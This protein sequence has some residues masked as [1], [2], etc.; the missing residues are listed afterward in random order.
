MFYKHYRSERA[1]AQ[2]IAKTSN[3]NIENNE[4]YCYWLDSSA[5]IEGIVENSSIG[6]KPKQIKIGVLNCSECDNF[7]ITKERS[8]GKNIVDTVRTIESKQPD[9]S[10]KKI[11]VKETFAKVTI[12]KKKNNDKENKK[13]GEITKEG[14][15]KRT[16]VA[17][18]VLNHLTENDDEAKAKMLSKIIDKGG[19][20]FVD[21]VVKNS[22]ALKEKATD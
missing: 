19:P 1:K 20:V 9:G 15:R 12:K 10:Y 2:K 16:I 5:N 4:N 18:N 22:K 14:K 21:N 3:I 11:V 7:T 17:E 6:A 13:E 8:S